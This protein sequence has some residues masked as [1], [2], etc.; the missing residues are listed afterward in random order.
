MSQ[1]IGLEEHLSNNHLIVKCYL[2][3]CE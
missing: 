1:E 3:N 2:S